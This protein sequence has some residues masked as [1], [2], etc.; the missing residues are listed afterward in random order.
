MGFSLSML[1]DHIIDMDETYR[2]V[3]S[4]LFGKPMEMGREREWETCAAHSAPASFAVLSSGCRRAASF[5]FFGDTA[6]QPSSLKV[7]SQSESEGL[8]KMRMN[9][10]KSF[11]ATMRN[12]MCK[13]VIKENDEGS[14]Y[15]SH[16]S[17]SSDCDADDQDV[18]CA[19]PLEIEE[20]VVEDV[21]KAR[22][23][24]KFADDCGKA[25]FIV[26]VASEPSD[27]PPKLSPSV[28]RR[29]RGDSFDEDKASH[30]PAPIWTTLFK[31]PAAEYIKFRENLENN[32]VSLENV[33]V[34]S[35]SYKIIGTIKVSNIS[36]E[37]SVFI[38]Y[39]MNGWASYMDKAAQ[40]QP[41]TSKLYDTFKFELDLPSSVDKIHKIEFC[42]C[43]KAGG[44][45]YWDSNSGSNYVLQCEQPQ[46]PSRRGSL[47]GSQRYLDH[48]DA[49]KLDYTEWGKF[50]SWK[51]LS[52][53]GPYW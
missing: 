22:K 29:Y 50:A 45:E 6:I 33:I 42:V 36:F 35:E 3:K 26:K 19:G 7:R 8:N 51:N 53:A 28:I 20:A 2:E 18:F 34:N 5:P 13:T 17:S 16:S 46:T 15:Q 12:R 21:K 39:T 47:F 44:T 40:F 23:C 1:V 27:C 10:I 49:Y 43:F 24:V 25:L 4:R 9:P 37:K 31:Q 14:D 48:D 41:S 52:T 32:K 11:D 30:E 38:R